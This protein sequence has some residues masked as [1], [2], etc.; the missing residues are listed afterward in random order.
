LV[1]TEEHI[2]VT[3]M[4]FSPDGKYL[5]VGCHARVIIYDTNRYTRIGT[6]KD[7]RQDGYNSALSF[8]A[9][10][11]WLVAGAHDRLIRVWDV[12]KRGIDR[13]L[14]GHQ[15]A[16]SGL[17]ISDAMIASSGDRTVRLWDLHG[18]DSGTHK[19]ILL[20]TIQADNEDEEDED[21]I[22]LSLAIA[23]R[24]NMVAAGTTS[25]IVFIW[26][27]SNGELVQQ[28][29]AHTGGINTVSFTTDGH[30][31]LAG[32]ADKQL[33]GWDLKRLRQDG[34]KV[35][36]STK[37]CGHKG[38]VFSLASSRGGDCIF[39]GHGSKDKYAIFG[40]SGSGDMLFKI[41]AHKKS[42]KAIDISPTSNI[43]ASASDDGRVCIWKYCTFRPSS[44]D[45][46]TNERVR[47]VI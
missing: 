22:I 47:G 31:L 10:G 15:G 2:G 25:N 33:L 28:L 18:V 36:P 38:E 34:S 17:Q 37:F 4:Q 12:E 45:G 40:H 1:H 39:S 21:L 26:D 11:K 43:M 46:N 35:I 27:M 30:W 29:H 9:D 7:E 41:W 8:S 6:L 13:V 24:S 32:G 20:P 44:P 16:I 42:V 23:P 19:I 14:T 5:A 3:C